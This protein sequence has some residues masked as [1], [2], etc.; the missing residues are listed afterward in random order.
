MSIEDRVTENEREIEYLADQIEDALDDARTC[1][2][3]ARDEPASEAVA[4][5]TDAIQSLQGILGWIECDLSGLDV[6]EDDDGVEDDAQDSAPDGT[7]AV[8]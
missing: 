6:E 1:V 4:S 3:R 7:P 5:I 8:A 2:R